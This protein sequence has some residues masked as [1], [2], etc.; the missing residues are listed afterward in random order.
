MLLHDCLDNEIKIISLLTAAGHMSCIL[1]GEA[2]KQQQEAAAAAADVEC[3]KPLT[4]NKADAMTSSQDT[5]LPY[6]ATSGKS[7]FIS[8]MKR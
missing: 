5:F 7:A 1:E 6:D 2:S 4:D 3:D 8:K